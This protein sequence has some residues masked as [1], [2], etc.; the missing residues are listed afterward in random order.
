VR[1]QVVFS[2]FA[3]TLICVMGCGGGGPALYPVSG[4][5][6]VGGKPTAGVS[7]TFAPVDGRP[8][9]AGKTNSSGAFVLVSSTGRSGAL[10]GKHK[11]ILSLQT[12]SSGGG[13]FADPAVREAEFKKREV[14]MKGGK[15][16]AP[17]AE[18]MKGAT[19]PPEYSNPQ[20]TPLEYEVKEQSNKFD[21]PVP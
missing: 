4:V 15:K 9:S 11:V 18:D 20:K 17:T 2:V 19:I 8:A 21:V 10:A 14:S 6:T 3:L 1:Y 5:V 12:E 13:N 16:G 7:V